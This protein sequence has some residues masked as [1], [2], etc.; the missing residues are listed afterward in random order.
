MAK[1][2]PAGQP[3]AAPGSWAAAMPGFA[4]VLPSEGRWEG[5]ASAPPPRGATPRGGPGSLGCTLGP[6][7][8]AQWHVGPSDLTGPLATPPHHLGGAGTEEPG[9]GGSLEWHPWLPW[10]A[11][12]CGTERRGPEGRGW[13]ARGAG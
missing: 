11:G 3:A 2:A 7:S 8:A 12:R 10:E 4:G 13:G 9:E 5:G 6:S 1:P